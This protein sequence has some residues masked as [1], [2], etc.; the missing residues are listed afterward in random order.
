M[1][2]NNCPKCGKKY[3]GDRW[4]NGRKL[5]QYCD[6]VGEKRIP[7]QKKILTKKKINVGEFSGFNFTVYDRYGHVRCYSCF[8]NKRSTAIK[9]MKSELKYGNIDAC[10]GPYTAVL[11][12]STVE[13][14]GEV[15]KDT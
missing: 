7:E 8:Y 10:A 3:L 1:K 13:V 9:E 4:Q 14:K 12:P 2:L 5:Q 15:F 6:C 11:W